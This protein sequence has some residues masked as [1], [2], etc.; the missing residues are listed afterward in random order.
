MQCWHLFFCI[1]RMHSSPCH[2]RILH[3]VIWSPLSMSSSD[4]SPLHHQRV[5]KKRRSQN[6]ADT[7]SVFLV[8]FFVFPPG[9][10]TAQSLCFLESSLSENKNIVCVSYLLIIEWAVNAIIQTKAICCACE[11][12]RL[13]WLQIIS[14]CALFVGMSVMRCAGHDIFVDVLQ[15]IRILPCKAYNMTLDLLTHSQFRRHSMQRERKERIE[16]VLCVRGHMKCRVICRWCIGNRSAILLVICSHIVFVFLYTSMVVQQKRTIVCDVC[17]CVSS[18]FLFLLAI[19]TYH[20]RWVFDGPFNV[21]ARC[22]Q[23]SW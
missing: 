16:L 4:L 9:M 22:L 5:M 13:L 18:Q 15:D 11:R 3:S 17:V 12:V 10:M 2:S 23:T 14:N 8:Y 1:V 19:L 7:W 6:R 21:F 20:L